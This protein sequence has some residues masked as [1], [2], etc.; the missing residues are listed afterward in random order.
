MRKILI[1]FISAFKI[2]SC[3]NNPSKEVVKETKIDLEAEYNKYVESNSNSGVFSDIQ[4]L[5]ECKNVVFNEYLE[6]EFS[7]KQNAIYS[8]SLRFA[9][10]EIVKQINDSIAYF[11]NDILRDFSKSDSYKK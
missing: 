2:S 8:A 10:Q 1:L 9:W 11:E 6:K 5:N 4:N 3:I 7:H